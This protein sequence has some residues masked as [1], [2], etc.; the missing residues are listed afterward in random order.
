M[1]Q[2]VF[3]FFFFFCFFLFITSYFRSMDLKVLFSL[4]KRNSLKKKKKLSPHR[5][6]EITSRTPKGPRTPGWEPLSST[7]KG[8]KL[9]CN[10]DALYEESSQ[11]T[12]TITSLL[13]AEEAKQEY[14]NT[15]A[16]ESTQHNEV[17][18]RQRDKGDTYKDYLKN[19]SVPGQS[20]TELVGASFSCLTRWVC[21]SLVLDLSWQW[22]LMLLQCSTGPFN[23]AAL[24]FCGAKGHSGF[25]HLLF[26]DIE[27]TVWDWILFQLVPPG[28]RRC[29]FQVLRWGHTV[30]W[31]I[32]LERVPPS[33]L[34]FRSN[35]GLALA[36]SVVMEWR[37]QVA[38]QQ[39]QPFVLLTPEELVTP[40]RL[41]LTI[42]APHTLSSVLTWHGAVLMCILSSC[43]AK[44]VLS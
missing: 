39:R 25:L 28:W 38:Q 33:S 15:W 43:V 13:S 3:F 7:I 2:V 17:Q 24:L 6:P 8:E 1:Y 30:K 34:V 21:S 32:V 11:S 42:I 10:R 35:K 29:D 16:G 37:R 41:W 27:R 9:R 19:T 18:D 4:L 23:A 14:W 5:P 26:I 40:P 22:R 20:S 36:A 44:S 12:N 31:D